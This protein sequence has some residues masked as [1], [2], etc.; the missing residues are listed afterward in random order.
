MTEQTHSN[1]DQSHPLY[2]I[3]RDHVDRMLAKAS[4]GDRDLVDL[5]RLFLRYEGFPGAADLKSDMKK[6]LDLWG[7][8]LDELNS[9]V[10]KLWAL[11]YIP[12]QAADESVGSG[13]DTSDRE[14]K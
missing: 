5:A 3:D 4:P 10:R 14:E 1:D 13:F 7:I 8:S 9:K 12:G 11:G 6:T 2:A